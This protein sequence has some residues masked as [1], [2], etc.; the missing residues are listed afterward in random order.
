MD[1]RRKPFQNIR[2]PAPARHLVFRRHPV[3]F[4]DEVNRILYPE[5]ICA[6]DPVVVERG[7]RRR[8]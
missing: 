6:I 7:N 8:R 2:T 5:A 1:G 3:Y 4:E